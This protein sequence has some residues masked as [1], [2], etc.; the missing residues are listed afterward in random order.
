MTTDCEASLTCYE[1][2]CMNIPVS[3][4]GD[5]CTMDVE[6]GNIDGVIGEC[7]DMMCAFLPTAHVWNPNYDGSNNGA[8][9]LES[10]NTH[11]ENQL[12]CTDTETGG[13]PTYTYTEGS[14]TPC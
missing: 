2:V 8:C 5:S 6:C 10:D 7:V 1:D 11:V 13:C 9:L 14:M 4:V 3:S 12:C